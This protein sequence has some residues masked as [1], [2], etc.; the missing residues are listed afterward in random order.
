MTNKKSIEF[1]TYINKLGHLVGVHYLTIPKSIIKKLGGQLK[2]RLVCTVNKSLSFPCGL[3]ALGNGDAY[4]SINAKRMK[5]LGLKNGDE[6]SI[7]LLE[8][9]S[10]FGMDMPQ[11]LTELFLQDEEGRRRFELLPPGKQRYIIYYVSLV[12][13]CQLRIDRALLLIG[14]L[15]NLP[16]GK[17]SFREMLGK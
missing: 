12:K 15:K 17:E 4:I 9:T 3:V 13:S 7:S 10:E 5:L 11:E 8:D 2:I 14:N 6:I 1:T 16:I